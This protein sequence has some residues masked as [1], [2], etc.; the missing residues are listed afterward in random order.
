MFGLHKTRRAGFRRFFEAHDG[1]V[2]VESVVWIPIYLLFI[3]LIVDVSLMFH[4]QA[5]A[6]R[7]A[8]D[9]NRAASFGLLETPGQVETAV[10]ARVRAISPSATVT[11]A[12]NSNTVSTTVTLPAS[13]LVALGFTKFLNID[14][15]VSSV[16][17]LES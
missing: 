5:K 12:M 2:T 6:M 9:G 1:S 17:L 16:H 8:Y 14:L 3:A 15:T 10:L 11:T 7:I 13:D 4:G